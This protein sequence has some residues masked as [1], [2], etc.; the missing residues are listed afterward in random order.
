MRYKIIDIL[1]GTTT[2]LLYKQLSSFHSSPEELHKEQEK[3]LGYF[4]CQIKKQN[5]LYSTYLSKIS[6][7]DIRQDPAT[8]LKI[9]PIVDK[10]FISQNRE[11]LFAPISK[12]KWQF[13]KT[14]GSTGEPF[15][16]AID[17]KSISESWAYTLWCWNKYADYT[18][19]D[20]YI[21]IAGSSLGGGSY[22]LK[23]QIYRTLQ[24]NYLISGDTISKDMNVHSHRIKKA[25][26]IF[27]YPSSMLALLETKP[28]LFLN[29]RLKAVFTTSEQLLSPVRKFIEKTLNVPVFDMY[30]ANDG[31]VISCECNHHNGFHYDPFNCFIET[32][33]NDVT[34][35]SELLLTSLNSLCFPFVRYR[36]GDMAEL[37]EFGSCN[38]GNPF[39]LIKNLSGRTR[40]VLKL[41]D[42]SY[43]HG[44]VFNRLFYQFPEVKRYKIVQ[45][46]DY[47]IT[48]LVDIDS[49]SE[50]KDSSKHKQMEDELLKTLKE[51]PF[52]I[53]ALKITSTGMQKFKL[54]ESHVS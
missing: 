35:Q 32:I 10:N 33:R 41:Q 6:D 9:L 27:C 31:G 38:C 13:K 22:R 21:T 42:G 25:K 4:L 26:L 7:V 54:I 52:L 48:I 44:V 53:E 16:Y 18:P 47:T 50:W 39:P 15:Q 20:P 24:N 37:G 43:V 34:G 40:D 11:N 12:R 36:V 28:T 23:T 17:L 46:K 19:G 1:R 51:T 8:V 45:T 5:P 2:S 29:H 30:G 14:G 49:F 3:R